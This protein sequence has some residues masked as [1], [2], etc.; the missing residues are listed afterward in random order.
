M[1]PPT[2]RFRPGR[3]RRARKT[4]TPAPRLTFSRATVPPQIPGCDNAYCKYAIVHG[5]DWTHLDG[6]EDGISQITRKTS[7][8]PD[9]PLE[10]YN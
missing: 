3:R 9:Q 1:S 5:D 8:G 2:A 6:P 10:Y 7:G 4:L